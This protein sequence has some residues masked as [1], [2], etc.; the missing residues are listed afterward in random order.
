[1]TAHNLENKGWL[2]HLKNRIPLGRLFEMQ[3]V[4]NIALFLASDNSSGIN[5]QAIV[6]D[7]GWTIHE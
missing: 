4:A 7:G 3:E 5:G 2:D 1:M 6:L